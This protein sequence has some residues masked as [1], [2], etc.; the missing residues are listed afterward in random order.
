MVEPHR[1]S[2]EKTV[3]E[4]EGTKTRL[5]GGEECHP[6]LTLTDEAVLADCYDPNSLSSTQPD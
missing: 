3:R 5:Q 2:R 1:E 6:V 4:A